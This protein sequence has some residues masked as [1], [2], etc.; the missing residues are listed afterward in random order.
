[1]KKKR[2]G[3]RGSLFLLCILL[4]SVCTAFLCVRYY[5][6][7]ISKIEN[8]NI[9]VI[10]KQDK[11][12]RLVDYKGKILFDA[13]VAIGKAVGNKRMS[14]DMR[15]PE[16]IFKVVDIQDAS[17]WT[18]DFGDGKGKIEGAYGDFFIRLEV[19]GHRGIG[20]HG[21]HLPESI[22][23]RASEGCVRLNNENLHTL[24]ELIAVPT[25][26]VITPSSEDEAVNSK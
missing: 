23:T 8:A 18:H 9:I 15:T 11:M 3:N 2:G 17:G 4:S 21:T 12:L 10:S 16:G 1:M 24:V 7:V 19:P 14:G 13:P 26:V 5:K 25:I 6:N 20:I 22:G